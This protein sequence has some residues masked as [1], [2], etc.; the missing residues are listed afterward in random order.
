M[1]GLLKRR[2][3][4]LGP[5]VARTKITTGIMTGNRRLVRDGEGLLARKARRSFLGSFLG[6]R[7]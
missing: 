7:R 4:G 5:A 3:A 6:R 2:R 1:F